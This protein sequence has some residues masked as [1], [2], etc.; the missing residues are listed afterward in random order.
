[1]TQNS[2]CRGRCAPVLALSLAPGLA[3]APALARALAPA[4][5]PTPDPALAPALAPAHD[6]ALDPAPVLAPDLASALALVLLLEPVGYG[7]RRP[8]SAGSTSLVLVARCR[9]P[10]ASIHRVNEDPMAAS[11]PRS[12]LSSATV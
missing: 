4:L 2:P 9:S 11:N 10:C 6:P 7:S 12:E 1:M 8:S 5:A 3:L